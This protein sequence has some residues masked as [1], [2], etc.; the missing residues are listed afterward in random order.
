MLIDYKKLTFYWF[1]N[2]FTIGGCAAEVAAW[3]RCVVH[4]ASALVFIYTNFSLF[5][6]PRPAATMAAKGQ[7]CRPCLTRPSA[8]S[9]LHTLQLQ[10]PSPAQLLERVPLKLVGGWSPRGM[11]RRSPVMM[12]ATLSACPRSHT[13][14]I[15]KSPTTHNTKTL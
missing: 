6:A 13:G 5:S 14:L 12:A 15:M 3:P 11:W 7:G 10:K 4:R 2:P 9:A 1:W 8:A